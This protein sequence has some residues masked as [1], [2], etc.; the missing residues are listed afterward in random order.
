MAAKWALEASWRPL[1]GLL[2]PLERLGRPRGGSQWIMGGSWMPLG[3]MLGPK[4]V[5]LNGS[6]PLQEE[7]QDRFQPSWRP[8]AFQK[9]AQKGAKTRSK[10]DSS[11]KTWFRQK[12]WFFQWNLNDFVVWDSS[13]VGRTS[14]SRGRRPGQQFCGPDSSSVDRDSSS[15]GS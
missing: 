1:G 15:G 13:L 5:V 4:K 8:K 9:G 10:S 6:W 14:N 7:F 3:A 12:L 11:S 2:E